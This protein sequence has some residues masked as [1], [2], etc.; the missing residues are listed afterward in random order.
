MQNRF[1]KFFSKIIKT[2]GVPDENTRVD[3]RSQDFIPFG[4]DNLFPQ[5][6]AVLNRRSP[7]HRGIINKKTEFTIADGY[8]A[9]EENT[10][11]TDYIKSVNSKQQSLDEVTE[12]LQLDFE[13]FGN[14]YM[15]IV[16]PAGDPDRINLFHKDSTTVRKRR[17]GRGAIHG[18]DKV[19]KEQAAMIL[20]P[21]WA[22]YDG[23][24]AFAKVL[25]VYPN[26]IEDEEGNKRS[27]WHWSS[28][29]PMYVHYG[30]PRWV[31]AMDAAGIAWKTNRWNIS[32][33]DNSFQ[34]SGILLV[35]G[36]MSE[37]DIETLQKDIKDNLV[38]YEN[39]G[40]LL[41]V[42]KPL[43][44]E[45]TKYTPI[46]EANEG[47]W[48]ELH[49]QSSQDL[50]SAHGWYRSLS[51]LS[52]PGQ[53]GNTQQIR[54]EYSLALP[55]IKKRQRLFTSV[56]QLLLGRTTQVDGESLRILNIAPISVLDLIDPNF[57]VKKG[58]GRKLAGLEV[59]KEDKRNEEFIKN[60]KDASNKPTDNPD[61]SN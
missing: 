29:E 2:P 41:L 7:T 8:V 35:D 11:L 31:A 17:P 32:R 40:N 6:L 48:I 43:G 55:A 45:G 33:L 51:G 59:D 52:E 28:Y 54:N 13:S 57:F 20:H 61:G 15:E 42:V 5:G 4:L 19:P 3:F 21:E 25:P 16:I 58:E 53:L 18:G 37:P 38:G 36:Q 34:T 47:D 26:F 23:T 49:S 50:I 12:R 24:K 10:E 46:S 56:Y 14:A 30:L 22:R 60:G 1:Q 27:I 39:I 44:G 9:D